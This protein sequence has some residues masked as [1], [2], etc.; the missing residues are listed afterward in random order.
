MWQAVGSIV[1]TLI[2]KGFQLFKINVITKRKLR[3][4][5]D[6]IKQDFEDLER[7]LIDRIKPMGTFTADDE[8]KV[9]RI[10]RDEIKHIKDDKFMKDLVKDVLVIFAPIPDDL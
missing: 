8:R 9:E 10:I 2:S 7:N 3:I 6:M 1:G 5:R 4:A